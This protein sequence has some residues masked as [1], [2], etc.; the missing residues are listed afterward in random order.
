MGAV[1]I[2]QKALYRAVGKAIADL[3]NNR[4][5][6]VSQAELARMLE[7]KR[8]TLSAIESG[9]Q[10]APLHLLYRIS[11]ELSVPLAELLPAVKDFVLQAERDAKRVPA[12]TQSVISR[13]KEGAREG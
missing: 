4:Q 9:K 2:D 12:K 8:T 10:K 7:V 5:P 3:R 13:L 11:N 1:V 6:K